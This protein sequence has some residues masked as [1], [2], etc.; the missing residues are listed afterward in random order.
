MEIKMKIKIL[1]FLSIFSCFK[2]SNCLECNEFNKT[3]KHIFGTKTNY[4]HSV[5]YFNLTNSLL[6][7]NF[8]PNTC[9][10]DKLFLISRHSTRNPSLTRTILFNELLPKL[11]NSLYQSLNNDKDMNNCK[12]YLYYHL[13]KYVYKYKLD[14]AAQIVD[15]GNEITS[16]IGNFILIC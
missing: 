2:F 1:I 16:E 15:V 4:N 8:V 6:N 10:L 7:L 9:K 11:K 12:Y 5:E 3:S 14:S 13:T